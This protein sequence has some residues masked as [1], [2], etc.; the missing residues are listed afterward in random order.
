MS[1]VN[2]NFIDRHV[3][4]K[5]FV[6]AFGAYGLLMGMMIYS[7]SLT[8]IDGGLLFTLNFPASLLMYNIDVIVDNYHAS[9][10]ITVFG[11]NPILVIPA[12]ALSWT[13]V[14]FLLH[15]ALKFF[16]TKNEI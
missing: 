15:F 2:T 12:N 1:T 11:H 5:W 4:R 6:C 13:A 9:E 10:T 16:T 14:G 7:Q 8:Q 3:N